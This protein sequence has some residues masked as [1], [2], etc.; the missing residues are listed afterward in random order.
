MVGQSAG[1]SAR[2]RPQADDSGGTASGGSRERRS[3]GRDRPDAVRGA[4]QRAQRP[5]CCREART[6]FLIA[7]PGRA[8]RI[9]WLWLTARAV[10]AACERSRLRRPAS[11]EAL[12]LGWRHI[13]DSTL[14]IERAVN[15]GRLKRPKTNRVHRSVDLLAP[16]AEDLATWRTASGRSPAASF[17][18]PRPDGQRGEPTTGTTRETATSI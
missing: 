11:A 4:P 3:P 2:V 10:R 9:R 17:V 1:I 7:P 13:R 18:F 6:P 14:L 16:L 12:G 15:D 5:P 8:P